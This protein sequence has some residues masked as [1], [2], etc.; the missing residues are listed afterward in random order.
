MRKI[1]ILLVDDDPSLREVTQY[2]L[3]RAGYEALTAGNGAEALELFTRHGP[4]VVVSDIV[5]PGM[6]GIELLKRVKGIAEET[7]FIIMTAHGSIE[8][9]VQAM[10]IGACDYIEKPFSSEAMRLSVEKALRIARLEREN[11]N[12]RMVVREKFRFENMIGNSG[13]MQEVFRVASLIAPKESTILL[14]GESG[15]GKDLLARA[16]HFHS[17]LREGPFIAVNMGAIPESLVDS[18]LFGHEKGSFTGAVARHCGAFER[19]DG[20]TLFLDEIAETRPD[21]Q[22]RL[23][24]ALQEREIKRVG[25]EE[26]LSVT[27]RVIAATNRDLEQRVREGKFREDLYYRLCVVPITLPPLRARKEDIPFLADYFLRKFCREAEVARLKIDEDAMRLL[28]A[29]SWPGNVRELENTM[30]R[31]VAVSAS[32][33]ITASS[34]PEKFQ[35]TR[36]AGKGLVIELPDGG[37]VLE[38]VEREILKSALKKNDYNQSASARFLGITR[39]TLLY[40]L[41]KYGLKEATGGRENNDE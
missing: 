30:E 29:Y 23:L 17:R 13:E 19:A 37:I 27:M 32:G 21:H 5:M 34:L 40:R 25:G 8:S 14:L 41:E 7:M 38:D 2:H 20:G 4:D 15:T 28:T 11:Q 22:V 6:D 10:K 39:N 36:S 9:A 24:R 26:I 1:T 31:C 12:L 35:G 18:E 3:E 33:T 16:I